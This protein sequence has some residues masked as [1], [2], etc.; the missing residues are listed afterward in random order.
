MERMGTLL[1]WSHWERFWHVSGMSLACLF[2]HGVTGNDSGFWHVFWRRLE[3]FWERRLNLVLRLYLV[4]HACL[5]LHAVRSCMLAL[6]WIHR[7]GVF[8]G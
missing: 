8:D 3:R 7:M 5:R 2:L 1:A 4:L 6:A